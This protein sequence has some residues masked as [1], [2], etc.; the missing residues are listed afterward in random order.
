MGT[1]EPSKLGLAEKS[2]NRA[3]RLEEFLFLLCPMRTRMPPCSFLHIP[4]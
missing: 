3:S 4:F 1:D 2:K